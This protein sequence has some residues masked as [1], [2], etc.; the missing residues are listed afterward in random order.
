MAKVS[1]SI[2]AEAAALAGCKVE[3]ME[4][5]GVF[6]IA[7]IQHPVTRTVYFWLGAMHKWRYIM[8]KEYPVERT[9]ME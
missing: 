2:E 5:G 1:A 3:M 4:V 6:K 8:A 9:K 7:S